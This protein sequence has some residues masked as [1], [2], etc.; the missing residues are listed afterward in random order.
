VADTVVG[1]LLAGNALTITNED[2]SFTV[3]N[4]G[5]TIIDGDFSILATDNK[6]R[7]FMNTDDGI[8]IQSNISGTW[9]DKFVVDATGNIVFSGDLSG[10]TGTFSGSISASSG[11]IGGWTIG[12]S[13]ISDTHGN[14]INSNGNIKLGGLLIQGSSARFD[15]DIYA[16]NLYGQVVSSSNIA[17]NG[18]S[19]DKIHGGT[20]SWSGVTIGTTGTGRSEIRANSFLDLKVGTSGVEVNSSN[21]IVDSSRIYLGTV[22]HALAVNAYSEFFGNVFFYGNIYSG[23]SVGLSTTVSPSSTLSFSDGL[24]VGVS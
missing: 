2:S 1:T 5:V 11:T 10:A 4:T 6:S 20:I 24:L 3:D 21:V 9:E 8:K 18:V 23:G 15:G 19:G 22:G 16:G 14:Y 7:I 12:A 17:N 13:G